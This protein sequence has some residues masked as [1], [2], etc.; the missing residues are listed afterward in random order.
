MS[1]NFLEYGTSWN[2]ANI[3][4]KF[5]SLL[6]T[7][8]LSLLIYLCQVPNLHLLWFPNDSLWPIRTAIP[9]ELH[10]WQSIKNTNLKL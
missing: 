9:V 5:I 4:I 3:D 1:I 2:M 8:R 6:V 7:F 10:Q